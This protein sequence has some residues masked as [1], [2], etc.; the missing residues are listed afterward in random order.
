MKKLLFC[1]WLLIFQFAQAEEKSVTL[2]LPTMNCA[3]C[4]ITVKKA[5]MSV[6]GIIDANVT[7][8]DRQAKV[9]FNDSKTNTDELI[10]V[11]TE[12]GYP[13]TELKKEGEL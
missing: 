13:S 7:Y 6:D 4:P 10:K 2:H 12:A 8:G 1:I 5:L 9:L 3:M 11:T